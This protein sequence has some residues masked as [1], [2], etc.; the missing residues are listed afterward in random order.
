MFNSKDVIEDRPAWRKKYELS[1]HRMLYV[2]GTIPVSMKRFHGMYWKINV[3]SMSN[4][5]DRM[6]TGETMLYKTFSIK[7]VVDHFNTPFKNTYF[8]RNLVAAAFGEKNVY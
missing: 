4:Y 6:S 8:F 5:S 3:G 1:D 2:F 7:N